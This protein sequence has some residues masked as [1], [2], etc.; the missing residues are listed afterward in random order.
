MSQKITKLAQLLKDRSISQRELIKLIHF[1]Y[2]D[3][4]QIGYDRMSKIVTGKVNNFSIKVPM[5]ISKV[6][7]VT[8]DEIIEENINLNEK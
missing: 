2:P 5:R 3:I 1:K 6:L 7:G 8:I 4:P